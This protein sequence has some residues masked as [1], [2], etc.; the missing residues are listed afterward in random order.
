M[1]H[2]LCTEAGSPTVHPF[3]KGQSSVS[4]EDVEELRSAWCARKRHPEEEEVMQR[5]SS[6]LLDT[7]VWFMDASHISPAVN[8]L[9]DP[10]GVHVRVRMG[11][12]LSLLDLCVLELSRFT[13]ALT[14]CSFLSTEYALSVQFCVR[15]LGKSLCDSLEFL[16]VSN[17]SPAMKKN[18]FGVF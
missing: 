10:C 15:C 17:A 1:V 14:C 18:L 4:R 5:A 11:K 16:D 7:L 6:L 2:G 13:A 9:W 12:S 3:G 8:L